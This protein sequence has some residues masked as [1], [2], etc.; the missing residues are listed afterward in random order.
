MSSFA[1]HLV[2]P[3]L[4]VMAT[5]L[6]PRKTVL[7]WV[8]FAVIN[9]FD[10]IFNFIG[11]YILKS[12]LLLHRAIL[13]N[14]F[15]GLP[16]AIIAVVLWRRMLRDHPSLRSESW[17]TRWEAFGAVRWGYG[18]VLATVFL[19]SHVFLD[20]FAGGV[21]LLWPIWNVY[22]YPQFIIWIDTQTGLPTTPTATVHTGEGAPALT[23]VYPWLTPGDLALLLLALIALVATLIAESRRATTPPAAAPEAAEADEG[24]D[25]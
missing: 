11:Y 9:D 25:R 24:S 10:F 8:P 6:F 5:Q 16:T 20:M 7:K 4:A 17:R 18:M 21:T 13:H 23:P 19:L 12:D 2:I 3:A 22:V 14:V 15:V 1:E